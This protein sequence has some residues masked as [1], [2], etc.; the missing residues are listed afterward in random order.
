MSGSTGRRRA[1]ALVYTNPRPG[2]SETGLRGLTA[3]PPAAGGEALLAAVEGNAPRVRADHPGAGGGHRV[4][5]N[6]FSRELGHAARLL[7]RGL[8]RHDAGPCPAAA[9]RC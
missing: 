2:H 5:L 6:D 8:Q 4:D 9:M 1:G 3:I 7:D